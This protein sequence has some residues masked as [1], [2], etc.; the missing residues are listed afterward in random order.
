MND[1]SSCFGWNSGHSVQ[2]VRR[3]R[4]LNG[5]ARHLRAGDTLVT[6]EP[7]PLSDG[8]HVLAVLEPDTELTVVAVE[9]EVIRVC[10]V[11]DGLSVV[12]TVN[13]RHLA[14]TALGLSHGRSER[15]LERGRQLLGC[16][17]LEEALAELDE[18]IRLTPDRALA[19]YL[20]GVAFSKQGAWQSAIG[21]YSDA[22]RLEPRFAN[23]LL[24]RAVAHSEAGSIQNAITDFT[25]AIAIQPNDY[26]AYCG[27]GFFYCLL[28]ASCCEWTPDQ[29]DEWIPTAA[30]SDCSTPD[31]LE[32]AISDLTRAIDLKPDVADV[33][34]A[35]AWAYELKG[36]DDLS[37]ADME[38]YRKRN[39]LS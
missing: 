39:A 28:H 13:K 38:S 32:R 12:G 8:G 27:R 36:E 17:E 25:A 1:G 21:A 18:S 11:I 23:A 19:Y 30:N 33:Y 20:R 2:S 29:M 24:S 3:P 7:A 6:I 14:R 4:R 34:Q 37:Q 15:H 9:A 16:S 22:I 10:A 5:D 31:Y 35:R 26:L